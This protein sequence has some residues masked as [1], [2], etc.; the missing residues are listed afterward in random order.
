MSAGNETSPLAVRNYQEQNSVE[1]SR[2]DS[3]M[4]TQHDEKSNTISDDGLPAVGYIS[5]RVAAQHLMISR[6]GI[7]RLLDAGE[8]PSQRIGERTRR[9][10]VA[11][12]RRYLKTG[13]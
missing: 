10:P 12:F 9:I 7:Y 3:L 2:M 4:L 1:A 13:R 5:P 6:P 11:E 8:I